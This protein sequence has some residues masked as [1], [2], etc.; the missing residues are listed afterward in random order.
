M[1]TL[2]AVSLY[3]TDNPF[4]SALARAHSNYSA[5]I[6]GRL[7]RLLDWKRPSARARLAND[8]FRAFIEHPAYPCLGAKSAINSGQYRL[9]AYG[10]L[11]SQAATEG[12]ARDLCAF[13]AERPLME[14]GYATFVAVYEDV[15]IVD[16]L[17]FEARLWAQLQALHDLDGQHFEYAAGVSSDPQHPRFAFSFAR[18]AFFVVGMHPGSSRIAR[19][20]PFP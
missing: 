4:A 5:F 7:V 3:S 11:G 19:R 1:K 18:S 13:V 16:E 17:E 12:L 6:N 2:Q 15:A 20:F 10:A 14:S 8:A 9:G